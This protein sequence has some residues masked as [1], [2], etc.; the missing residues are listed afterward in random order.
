MFSVSTNP[1]KNLIG[2]RLQVPI[3][4]LRAAF[5]NGLKHNLISINQLCDA[6]YKVLF[7]KT[8][9]TTFNQNDEVA[10]ISPR[11]KDVYVIDISRVRNSETA[12]AYECLYVNFLPEMEPK[13]LIEALKEEGWI[14]VRQEELNQF[15]KNKKIRISERVSSVFER[16]TEKQESS[17]HRGTWMQP[18]L[19]NPKVINMELII[20]DEQCLVQDETCTASLVLFKKEVK[21]L[22]NGV[23]AYQ[24][25][26]TRERYAFK[27]NIDDCQLKKELPLWTVLKISDDHEIINALILLIT[28]SKDQTSDVVV[29]DTNVPQ[30][31]LCSCSVVAASLQCFGF[32]LFLLTG[33]LAASGSDCL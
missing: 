18:M 8:K 28:P 3:E 20:M 9:G 6:N 32:Q 2:L 33:C 19:N 1:M 14:I 24:L 12:S 16:G 27:I 10:L 17:R 11:R 29:K 25:L 26:A 30:L 4:G 21:S 22:L 15:E 13:K 31:V 7:T 5:V 23:S